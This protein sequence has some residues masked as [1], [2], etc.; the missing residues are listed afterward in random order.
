MTIL[1]I[2]R[3]NA[4]RSQIAEALFNKYSKSNK[5]ISAGTHATIYSG[6]KLSNVVS[7]VIKCMNEV[8]LNLSD[9]IQK[10]LTKQIVD[11]ADRIIVLTEKKDLPQYILKYKK[12]TY[13]N[14][15]DGAGKDYEFHVNMRNKIDSLVKK[16]IHEIDK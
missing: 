16:L 1:F 5:A 14:I 8:D 4:G 10:P 13:W 12:V 11:K 9:K 2:C 15:E 7:M 6:T 3:W